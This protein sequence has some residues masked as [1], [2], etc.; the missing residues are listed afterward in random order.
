VDGVGGAMQ[1]QG[2][3]LAPAPVLA[4]G[5][6][7]RLAKLEARENTRARDNCEE[8]GIEIT[9]RTEND[10]WKNVDEKKEQQST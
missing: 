9:D 5:M 10:G 8:R 6:A 1:H 4:I 3:L 7:R 2:Q